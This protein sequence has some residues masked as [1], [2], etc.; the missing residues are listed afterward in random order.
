M[1]EPVKERE[2]EATGR[3]PGNT[4]TGTS[5]SV[6]PVTADLEAALLSWAATRPAGALLFPNRA[7]TTSRVCNYT[8]RV[9]KHWRGIT[10]LGHQCMRRTCGTHFAAT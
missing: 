1:D 10:D 6:V 5:D 3:R 7:G 4:K 9:L 8:K 2:R